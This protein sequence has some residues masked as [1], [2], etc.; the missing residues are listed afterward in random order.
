MSAITYTV[1]VYMEDTD[2]EIKISHYGGSYG[3]I[4][5]PRENTEQML[6]AEQIRNVGKACTRIADIMCE[7]K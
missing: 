6:T 3:T 4:E 1:S 7:T 2:Q 5:L